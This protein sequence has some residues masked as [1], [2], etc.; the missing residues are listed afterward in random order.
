MFT[1]IFFMINTTKSDNDSTKLRH[2]QRLKKF[3]E[4]SAFFFN[5]FF[6][7]LDMFRLDR[8]LDLIFKIHNVGMMKNGVDLKIDASTAYNSHQSS[9][10]AFRQK[11]RPLVLCKTG[12]HF[13]PLLSFVAFDFTTTRKI[14]SGIHTAKIHQ[15]RSRCPKLN[16]LL[17]PKSWL[18]IKIQF[19]QRF[20]ICMKNLL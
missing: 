17:K 13:S 4:V 9:Q 16:F 12:S 20:G 2:F 14:S 6:V 5:G 18:R 11:E 8:K 3:F 15:L 19:V 10:I 1:R 7:R